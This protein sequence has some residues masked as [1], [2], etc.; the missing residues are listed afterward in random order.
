MPLVD[1]TETVRVDL[2][3]AGE[4]VDVRAHLSRG[5]EIEIRRRLVA[6]ARVVPGSELMALDAA[7]AV[8]AAE[9]ARLELAIIAWSFDPAVTPTS[10]RQ[11]DGESVDAIKGRLDQLYA[12]RTDAE[13][14]GSGGSGP[15]RLAARA[16][17]QLSSAG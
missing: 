3:A 6:G 7:D 13:K 12:P 8:E 17:A 2:P 9:F 11:L 4:W 15:T 1:R 14:K 16:P 5:D 10:I